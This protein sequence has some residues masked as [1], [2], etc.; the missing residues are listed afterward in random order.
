M[1]ITLKM[2][3]DAWSAPPKSAAEKDAEHARWLEERR[4][5]MEADAG[6][7]PHFDDSHFVFSSG[8]RV[9]CHDG[10]FG[11]KTDGTGFEIGY[12]S[13][14]PINYPSLDYEEDD[15]KLTADDMR[16]IAD[17]MIGRWQAFRQSLEDK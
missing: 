8:R 15:F 11:V 4:A 9:Y 13:D 3:K 17:M 10:M 6:K 2:I 14:G 7:P 16:E 1:A 12:G 5:Q